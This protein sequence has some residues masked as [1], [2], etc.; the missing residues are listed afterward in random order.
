[1][2]NEV[3]IYA[4]SDTPRLRYVLD[5]IFVQIYQVKYHLTTIQSTFYESK[6]VKL[7]YSSTELGGLHIVPSEI[8]FRDDLAPLS[9]KIDNSNPRLPLYFSGEKH[10]DVL[11]ASFYLCSRYE[12]YLPFRADVHNRFPAQESVL[13]KFDVLNTPIVNK[14]A[15]QLMEDLHMRCPTFRFKKPNFRF[16]STIDV[17]QAW[18]YKYKGLRRNIGGFLRDTIKGDFDAVKERRDVLKGRMDDPFYTFG[19]LQTL[20]NQ[21]QTNCQYFIQVGSHGRFDKNHSIKHPKFIELIKRIATE[22]KI[23]IHPSYA[24][25]KKFEKVEKEKSSL[26]LVIQDNIISSRQHF[27]MHSMRDTYQNLLKLGIKEDHTMG[28][29]TNMGF[30]AGIAHPFY[31]FNLYNNETTELLLFPFC[32]MDITPMHYM[33][34]QIDEAKKVVHDQIEVIRKYGGLYISLWHNESLSENGRWKGWKS[35]YTYVLELCQKAIAEEAT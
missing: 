1:M 32:L 19:E 4:Q 7:N 29:S 20:H 27:L 14:W 15:R 5:L 26:E 13:H 11:A 35:L 25:N 9:V 28:Y 17:D 31:Y 8:L 16:I 34:L 22:N 18:K 3:L 33:G 21:Y 23:G 24:S 10:F 2:E 30:R 6:S 12:E